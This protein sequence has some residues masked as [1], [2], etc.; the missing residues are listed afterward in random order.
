ME[1]SPR[2][3][4]AAMSRTLSDM[5]PDDRFHPPASEPGSGRSREC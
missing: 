2:D 4:V 1:P 5:H 3:T